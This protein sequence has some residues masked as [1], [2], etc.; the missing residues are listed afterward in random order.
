MRYV[1]FIVENYKA[2]TGPLEVDVDKNPLLPI[3]GVNESGKTTILHAIFAFDHFN[4]TLN[5]DGRHLKDTSNLYRTSSPD[6]TISA[7]I[8]ISSAEFVKV[9]DGIEGDANLK[10]AVKSYRRK[11]KLIPDRL[12]VV[13]NLKTLEYDI[14]SPELAHKRLNDE[15]AKGILGYLPY[16]LYF[17]DF[18]DSIEETIEILE[19][20]RDAPKGWLAIMDRLFEQTDEEFS[21]F[22]LPQTE[23]RNRKGILAK[24]MRKLNGTL[25]REWQNFR[26][27]GSNALEISI[28]FNQEHSGEAARNFLKLEVVETD[29]DGDEH[30]FFIRDRS[31]GFFWFFNFVMKLEFNPKVL[32]GGDRDT[33]YLLD[34]PGSYLHASAQSKLC[35][36]LRH[37]SDKNRVIYCTHSHYLLNPEVIPLSTIKVA[38]K[39]R[40]GNIKLV[41]IYEHKGNILEKRSAFQP[42]VDALQ[43]K[44]FLLDMSQQKIIITEGICDYYALDMFKHVRSVGIL[45]SVGADSIR[46]YV[47]L[48]I[49]WRVPYSVLWDNDQAGRNAKTRAEKVF[50]DEVSRQHFFLLP[51]RSGRRSRVLQDLF[52]GEDLR[53]IKEVLN[54]PTN[55]SFE[56]TIASLY[57]ATNRMEV[58]NKISRKTRENFDEV[59]AVV[60]DS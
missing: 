36:K 18:R 33:I 29:V 42:V 41:S 38:D 6:A 19:P 53:M 54:I 10:R 37:L 21:V 4:D 26:L 59:F 5:E 55:S 8:E 31:K 20:Q 35:Q 17:D 58:L 13:R 57:Y 32:E 34:E 25:T 50:G 27:D 24:V 39:D 52:A 60:T 43:I 14:D 23:E 1:K 45:P 7:E 3:I 47:S 9:L 44:P 46:Y 40:R 11:R 48:M 49:A 28:E 22:D 2:I 30:Y 16:I 15:L 51:L 12:V 56:K